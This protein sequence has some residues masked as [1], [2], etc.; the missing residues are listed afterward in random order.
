MN[1]QEPIRTPKFLDWDELVQEDKVHRLIYTDE[2]IFQEEMRKI[3]GGVWVFLGHE[4]Q[5]PEK[6][7]FIRGKLGLRPIILTR[8]SGGK[9]RALYNRCTHRSSTVCR[10]DK[11]NSKSFAC[12][13]H[14]WSF[15][16]SGK[17]SGVPWPEGY[18]C[19]FSE[20]KF[21]L[22]QVPR[23]KSYR[24]FIFGTLNLDAPSLET[25]L[26]G[27]RAPLDEWLD[28]HPGGTIAFC[29][30]N[31][32]SNRVSSSKQASFSNSRRMR[33]RV[34]KSV[35]SASGCCQSW[36]PSTRDWYHSSDT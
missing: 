5:I 14:G 15:F 22:A 16:N 35:I 23:V 24:G 9:I 30:A 3:W 32:S 18:S 28:R 17:L 8:D 26:S 25:Y 31:Q 11:G 12:P 34:F 29:D 19:D 10:E 4:S 27:V 21:N 6:N 2:A 33:S 36:Y 7:D 13:Y 20:S 1:I